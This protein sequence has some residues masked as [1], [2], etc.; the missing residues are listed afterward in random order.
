MRKI[1]IVA[2]IVTVLSIIIGTAGVASA[3]TRYHTWAHGVSVRS[4]DELHW[5]DCDNSPSVANCSKV[6]KVIN[7]D[8]GVV[9]TCQK[10]G[11]VV[12]GNPNWLRVEIYYPGSSGLS[13][14]GWMASY[15]I[16]YP[17]N[18]LPIPWC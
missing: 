3:A 16:D 8:W 7:P 12:G 4:G 17:K 5:A 14:V 9:P 10:A 15:Y 13:T 1:G 6:Q 2:A 11:Q 18:V